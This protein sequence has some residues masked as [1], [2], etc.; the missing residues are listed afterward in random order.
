M[1]KGD[2]LICLFV[3]DYSL[4]DKFTHWPLHIT[5][6]PWF[7]NDLSTDRII[8]EICKELQSYASF[9][10]NISQEAY[11]GSKKDKLVNLIKPDKTL[12]SIE[13]TIRSYLKAKRSWIVDETTKRKIQ[14]S[15]H[16]T[17]QS[18]ERLI[19]GDK[20]KINKIY[21]IEQKEENKEVVGIININ[22]K[23]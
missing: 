17:V 4:G 2:K 9:S 14:Y 21:L 16:V 18:S 3:Q 22:G 8:E 23:N 6:L 5:I 19:A 20:I 13:K 11:F 7:R 12:S 10:L 1:L 15:P